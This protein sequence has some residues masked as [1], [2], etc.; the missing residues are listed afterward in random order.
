MPDLKLVCVLNIRRDS[1]KRRVKFFLASVMVW[2]SISSRRKG[3]K[4]QF[5]EG[6][7]DTNKYL[8]ILEKS[9]FKMKA[10]LSY[11]L[12]CFFKFIIRL[13]F[14]FLFSVCVIYRNWNGNELVVWKCNFCNIWKHV[15]S[16]YFLIKFNVQS[17][18]YRK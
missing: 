8:D 15:Y 13:P 6:T 1:L 4:F 5:I 2:S 14:L 16:H 7:V 10:L 17:W 11:S 12:K 18:Q 3:K 9:F